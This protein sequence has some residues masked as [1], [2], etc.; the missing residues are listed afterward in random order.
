MVFS[1]AM[2]I[3]QPSRL[4]TNKNQYQRFLVSPAFRV[5]REVGFL[6]LTFL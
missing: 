6:P 5:L 1:V 3:S 2:R 4:E